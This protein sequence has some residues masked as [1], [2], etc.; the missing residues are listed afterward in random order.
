VHL[1][2]I[3][4]AISS[5]KVGD[6]FCLESGVT[7]IMSHLMQ[8]IVKESTGNWNIR[9][10]L[11]GSSVKCD[12]QE[13]RKVTNFSGFK[14][15]GFRFDETEAHLADERKKLQKAALGL[16]DSDDEDSAVDVSALT[17]ATRNSRFTV[18]TC[19]ASSSSSGEKFV[20]ITDCD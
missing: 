4:P 13:G 6:F 18:A 17:T 9:L 11:V 15:K 14:G 3:L 1:Y 10:K 7:M 19:T 16:H 8:S 5:G 2:D 20:K 12:V